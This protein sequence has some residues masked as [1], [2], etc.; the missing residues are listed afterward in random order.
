MA[1]NPNAGGGGEMATR[2]TDMADRVET[3]A[4]RIAGL[5]DWNEE[6]HRALGALVRAAEALEPVLE[7]L[8][9]D[10]QPPGGGG[11]TYG[12]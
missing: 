8:E 3:L 2:A 11:R 10:A 7:R 9:I 12:G 4:R 5:L 6:D 1:I